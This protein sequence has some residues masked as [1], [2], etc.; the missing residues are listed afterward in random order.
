MGSLMEIIHHI[1]AHGQ[2]LEQTIFF[3]LDEVWIK[4]INSSF[5]G[6][7]LGLFQFF[8]LPEDKFVI[9]NG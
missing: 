5:R 8:F 7:S 2:T 6:V 3:F 9:I 4:N 1:L